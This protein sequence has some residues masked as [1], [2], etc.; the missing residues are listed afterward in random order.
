MMTNTTRPSRGATRVLALVL[1]AGAVSCSPGS[2]P[3]SPTPI[4]QVGGGGR[5]EGT[6]TYRRTGGTFQ[7]NETPQGLTMSLSLGSLQD[8][9]TGSFR[10]ASSSGSLQGVIAGNMVNGTFRATVLLTVTGDSGVASST[11]ASVR[12]IVG[13]EGRGE[14]TGQFNGTNISWDIGS[15]TYTNCNLATSSQAT[16]VA[17]TPVPAPPP[18]SERPKANVVITV[19]PSTTLAR[20]T[21]SNG[22]SGHELTVEIAETGGVGIALDNEIVTEERRG[23]TI[24]TERVE[25]TFPRIEAGEKR[26][27]TA[28]ETET[29]PGTYQVF[30][31]GTDDNGNRIRFATPIITFL[32]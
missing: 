10:T 27:W 30:F 31:S 22:R 4:L 14:A 12:A 26:R 17:T 13:C 16:A 11:S 2:L 1:A 19:L 25:S 24:T 28:C 5:Y 7:I 9:F 15:I 32:P 29:V 18:A 21:C 6:M 23:G 20:T 8:Q 3:G